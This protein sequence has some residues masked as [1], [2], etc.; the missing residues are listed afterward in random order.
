VADGGGELARGERDVTR[1]LAVTVK[2]GGHLA[3]PARAAG[4][5]LAELGAELGADLY[6]GHGKTLL[7]RFL[8]HVCGG[9]SG[10]RAGAARGAETASTASITELP[11]TIGR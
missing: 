2:H 11:E 8:K 3:G 6:L 4:S 1:L 5:T 10:A 7:I 9:L